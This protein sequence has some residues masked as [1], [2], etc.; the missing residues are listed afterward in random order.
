MHVQENDRIA[1]EYN[2]KPREGQVTLIEHS[3]AGEAYFQLLT[4]AD[5]VKTFRFDRVEG[6][7]DVLEAANWDSDDVD[8]YF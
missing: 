4:T 5:E 8:A 7:I 2:G 3:K 6:V 1:F